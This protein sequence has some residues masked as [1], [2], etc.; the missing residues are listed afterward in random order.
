MFKQ[1][2]A[3]LALPIMTLQAQDDSR[4][5]REPPPAITI[6]STAEIKVS[7]DRARINISV[8]TK[9]E[10]AA[11]AATENAQKQTAVLNALKALGLKDDQLSTANYNVSPSYRYEQNR[12]PILTGYTVTNTIVAEIRDIKQVGPV[13]DAALKNG[14]NMISSLD[15]YAS[16]T[17]AA[18]QKAISEAV[19][20]A[21]AEAA[22]A[23]TAAGGTIGTLL[24]LNVNADRPMPRPVPMYTK[25]AGLESADMAT[26]INPGEQTV[27]VTVYTRWKYNSSK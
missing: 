19:A 8:Q 25:A 6:S 17:D 18:R 27:S 13:I 1:F 26:P 4:D 10:T 3:L 22:I 24:E 20:S 9:H 16:N 11:G 7:P 15:F 14:S 23:A 5:Y 2:V 12:D 21:R